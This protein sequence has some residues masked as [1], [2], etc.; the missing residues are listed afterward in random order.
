MEGSHGLLWHI[1]NFEESFLLTSKNNVLTQLVEELIEL[2]I[3]R[4]PFIHT[5]QSKQKSRYLDSIKRQKENN[6]IDNDNNEKNNHHNDDKYNNDDN[7][8]FRNDDKKDININKD[9]NPNNLKT[10]NNNRKDIANSIWET[11]SLETAVENVRSAARPRAILNHVQYI[12]AVLPKNEKD[13]FSNIND[14]DN[15]DRNDD[16]DDNADNNKNFNSST[17]TSS[18]SSSTH[19]PDPYHSEAFAIFSSKNLK[20]LKL[21]YEITW[22]PIISIIS[23]PLLNVTAKITKRLLHFAQLNALIKFVWKDMRGRKNDINLN[24]N[25]I[26]KSKKLDKNLD[27][28]SPSSSS[29]LFE[30]FDKNCSHA[31]RIIQQTLQPLQDFT[32]DRI[33]IKQLK[34]KKTF[35]DASNHGLAG[36]NHALSSYIEGAFT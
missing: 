32:S 23:P 25:D 8:E 17:P 36:V 18:S 12:I 10:N 35:I 13:K 20:N 27:K 26:D 33:R 2:H 6:S 24:K 30:T 9:S 21:S 3:Q 16:Y 34:F 31:I 15:N 7:Y 22:Q 4:Y 29:P 1:D 11:Y 5:I 14:N 28:T 19:H